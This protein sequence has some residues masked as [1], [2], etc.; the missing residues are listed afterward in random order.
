MPTLASLR[1]ACPWLRRIFADGA[2]GGDKVATALAAM[3]F[4]DWATARCGL[5][6]SVLPRRWAL[7][8]TFDR[9][10]RSR[11]LAKHVDGTIECATAWLFLASVKL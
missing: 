8:R 7:D 6:F 9:F 5:G 10:N 2:Y 3:D 1:H 11:R 4:A